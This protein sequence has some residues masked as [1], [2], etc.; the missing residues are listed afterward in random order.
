MKH[1]EVSVPYRGF[2]ILNKK[3]GRKFHFPEN[4]SVPYRGF[5]IL[6][7]RSANF[8]KSSKKGFRPLSGL[9]YSKFADIR[10]YVLADLSAV[11]DKCSISKILCNGAK[12]YQLTAKA[13]TGGIPVFKMP[14]TSPANVRFDKTAWQD[15]LFNN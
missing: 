3:G 15:K 2:I 13:Y 14:S 7:H 6:N 1:L 10:D 5:I 8:N 9:Y 4:V 11:L 12:A